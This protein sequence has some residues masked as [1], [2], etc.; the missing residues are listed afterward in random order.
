MAIFLVVSKQNGVNQ[1]VTII[2][3][4][5]ILTIRKYERF[6]KGHSLPNRNTKI[7]PLLS[8]ASKLKFSEFDHFTSLC[9]R[10]RLSKLL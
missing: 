5:T 1:Y 6:Q 8:T 4:L 3:K 9:G 7:S 10:I 2:P